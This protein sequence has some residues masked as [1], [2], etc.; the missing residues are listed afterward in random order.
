MQPLFSLQ[1]TILRQIEIKKMLHKLK[2]MRKRDAK[3]TAKHNS[4]MEHLR[5]FDNLH[6]DQHI[7]S[8]IT[9]LKTLGSL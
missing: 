8:L 2:N 1:F 9:T 5:D 7:S 6:P 3:I 4:V